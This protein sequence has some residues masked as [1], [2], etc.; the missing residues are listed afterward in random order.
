[1]RRNRRCFC[2]G[3]SHLPE[4]RYLP[5]NFRLRRKAARAK[6]G[7]GGSGGGL[8]SPSASLSKYFFDKFKRRPHGRR[9]SVCVL[10][11]RQPKQ[12]AFRKRSLVT[13]FLC[14]LSFLDVYGFRGNLFRLPVAGRQQALGGFALCQLA[15][16][17][18][19]QTMPSGWGFPP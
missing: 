2:A 12:P 3:K 13:D 19:R 8:A 14:F 16:R 4:K 10:L 15:E 11:Q 7:E 9:F 1:M 6:V 18:P 17:F 5:C